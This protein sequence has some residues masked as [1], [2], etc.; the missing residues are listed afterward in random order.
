MAKKGNSSLSGCIDQAVLRRTN[1][2]NLVIFLFIYMY[3]P[4]TLDALIN[5]N[6][7]INKS[8]NCCIAL[9]LFSFVQYLF[10]GGI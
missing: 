7:L 6:K 4:E 10:E 1:Y 8:G 3:I 9:S 5:V 2:D